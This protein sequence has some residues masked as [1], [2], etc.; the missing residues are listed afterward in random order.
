VKTR[1]ALLDQLAS[2]KTRIIGFHLAEGGTG[3][4]DKT[5]SGYNF[6]AEE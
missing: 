1:V 2:E 5:T 3:Y 4:V 6:V